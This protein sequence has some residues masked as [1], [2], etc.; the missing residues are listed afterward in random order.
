MITLIFIILGL[1]TFWILKDQIKANSEINL[2]PTF[3]NGIKNKFPL[4]FKDSY[5]KGFD[6]MSEKKSEVILRK[7]ISEQNLFCSIHIN[8]VV[9]N[10]IQI[11]IQTNKINPKYHLATKTYKCPATIGDESFKKN[12][13]MSLLDFDLCISNYIPWRIL[14]K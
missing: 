7:V 1:V 9:D 6:I 5:L 11:L 12:I 4:S 3:N 14:E 13:Q 8:Y 2:D 10:K